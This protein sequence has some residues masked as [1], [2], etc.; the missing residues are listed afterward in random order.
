MKIAF[1][2]SE[3]PHPKTGFA[4]GIGTSIMNLSKG[5]SEEGHQVTI[6]IYGQNQDEKFID[7]GVTFYK[8]KNIKVKGFSRILTQKK[9]RRLLNNLV[10]NSEIDIVEAPDWTGIT[11]FIQPKC[12]IV[13]RLHGS[14]TYFCH[15]EGRQVKF[16]NRFHEKRALFNANTLLS[17]SQF[18]ADVTKE[19]FQLKN[20]ISIIPNAIA[21][22]AFKSNQTKLESNNVVLYF[23]TLIR[24][25][26][27]LELPLIFNEVVK[28]NPKAELRLIG[29][30]SADVFSGSS[31]TWQLMVPL[32]SKEALKQT[33]YNGG[34]PYEFMQKQID[35]ASVCVFPT[36]AEALPVSWLEAMAMK[37]AIVASNIGWAKELL[38]DGVSGYLV[39]PKQHHQYA[40][41]IVE[42]LNSPEK[43][44]IFGQNAFENIINNFESKIVAQ[45][46]ADF[47]L[48]IINEKV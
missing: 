25:K 37:K 22:D 45:K 46:A 12:P 29:K 33:T 48:K 1:L 14:D 30:D 3:Y 36:F 31:S 17:V 7:Q 38:V 16:W 35:L 6:V 9:I 43:A 34:M 28:S 39:H 15:L 11:S 42:L 23:G 26:G 5:L 13:I 20:E 41:K 4:G 27:A 10:D 44:S 19:L 47:Y 8:I 21:I 2:T 24:K 32:F 40:L 18:T